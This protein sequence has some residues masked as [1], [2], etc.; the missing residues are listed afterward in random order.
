M[1]IFFG[2]PGKGKCINDV[3]DDMLVL[4]TVWQF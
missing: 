1:G 2:F 4:K 3:N